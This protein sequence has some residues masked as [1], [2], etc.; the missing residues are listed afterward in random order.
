MNQYFL[1]FHKFICDFILE[2]FR[3]LKL[4][5][6]IVKPREKIKAKAK[7]FSSVSITLRNNLKSF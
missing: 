7:S 1:K 4:K 3:N 6:I 2:F 5:L